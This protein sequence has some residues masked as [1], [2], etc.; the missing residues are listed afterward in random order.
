MSETAIDLNGSAWTTQNSNDMV[1]SGISDAAQRASLLRSFTAVPGT[2]TG[3]VH[4][5]W[6]YVSGFTPSEPTYPG[7]GG[8]IYTGT[9]V[10]GPGTTK[11]FKISVPA[12]ANYPYEIYGNPTLADL[13]WK[14]L[15]FSITQTGTIDRNKL[16]LCALAL[17][18]GT[19]QASVAYGSISN[20]DCVNDT[21][22][23][24]HGFES[25]LKDCHSTDVSYSYDY[26]HHGT[27]HITEDNSVPGH[28]KCIIKWESAKKADGTWGA[29]TAIPSGPISPTNGHQFTNPSVNY[30]GEHFGVGFKVQPSAVVY[31]WLLDNGAGALVQGPVVNVMPPTFTYCPAL[32][33]APAQMQAAIVR[34]PQVPVLEFGKG[35]RVKKSRTTT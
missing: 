12:Y 29:F 23:E 8:F 33:G 20:F 25:G 21:G 28:P 35:T 19:A 11:R 10:A 22:H 18:T 13:E 2:T 16:L 6:D 3:E 14:A 27:S 32:G 26:N 34:V 5:M 15:P 7:S 30:D 17:G 4:A 9:L 31:H 1:F 24:C